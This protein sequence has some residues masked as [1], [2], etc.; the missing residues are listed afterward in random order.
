M[1]QTRDTIVKLLSNIASKKELE[2]YLRR[3][4]SGDSQKFAV[5]KVGG[6]IMQGNLEVL[7]AAL[8]FLQEVGLC[9]IVVHGQPPAIEGAPSRPGVGGAAEDQPLSPEGLDELCRSAQHENLR[10]VE[11]LEAQGCRAR[12]VTSG[13]FRAA[14]AHEGRLGMTGTVV[15]VDLT[16][17]SSSIRSGQLPIVSS[18]GATA[19]GQI[20][21]LTA[22]DATHALACAV[23]PYKVVFLTAQGGLRDIRGEVL[24]AVNLAEDYEP[25][26]IEGTLEPQSRERL[27]RVRELCLALPRGSSVSV[28]SPEHLARE[29]FT[30]GGAGTLVQRGEKVE[31]F[32]SFDA[33]DRERLRALLETC[34]GRRLTPDYF[35][36]K[37]CFRV[38]VTEAYRATAILTREAGLPYLDKFAVTTRAQGEGFGSSLWARMRRE[39]ECLFWRS[40]VRNPIN[41]WYFQNSDGSLRTDR[42][43]VFW[44]GMR[45]FD[46][47]KLCIDTALA[48]P[49]SLKEH[50]S[51]DPETT[52]GATVPPPAVAET[53][54]RVAEPGG[55]AP[56][57]EGA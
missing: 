50:G 17:V 48:L 33:L 32:T 29:L 40:Q 15:G 31:L 37:S 12:P 42:W 5:I 43:V 22:A 20:L 3:F 41:P 25:L 16:A 46:D 56:V 28:T 23:E 49:P 55:P 30:Y 8:G 35:Q 53:V 9:P 52:D 1:A 6:S 18:L 13:V 34:F 10:L 24:S 19:G 45:S 47:I 4:S 51:D 2:Q 14:L 36:K 57:P 21:G 38:Y 44:Y 27:G 7:A 39:N 54:R 11:A 26:M